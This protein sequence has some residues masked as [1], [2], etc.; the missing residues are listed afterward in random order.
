MDPGKKQT[1]QAHKQKYRQTNAKHWCE[2]CRLFIQPNDLSRRRHE[3][4]GQHQDAVR[5]HVGRIQKEEREKGRLLG[6][7][8]QRAGHVFEQEADQV[9]G[10]VKLEGLYQK[11]GEAVKGVPVPVLS[12]KP[13]VPRS[14]AMKAQVPVGA[15]PAMKETQQATI[16]HAER[17]EK[18]K[19]MAQTAIVG[20]WVEVDEDEAKL[21]NERRKV[22]EE[23]YPEDDA[24]PVYMNKELIRE[25]FVLEE[26]VLP[27]AAPDT[28]P[29][30]FVKRS[31]P[32]SRRNIRR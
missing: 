9:K 32:A 21:V 30:D 5:R 10:Q 26:K 31:A 7:F 24:K 29:V 16:V 25:E 17:E 3:T 4:S 20:Q 12:V 22:D 23:A 8:A 14:V 28:A 1:K 6:E 15:A 2:F 27:G 11:A 19:F 18:E 13:P